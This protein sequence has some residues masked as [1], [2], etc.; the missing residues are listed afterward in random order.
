MDEN[1][2]LKRTQRGV[3]LRC[4]VIA[5]G[6]IGMVS[7]CIGIFYTTLAE[8]MHTGIGAIS[9]LVTVTSIT[10]ALV[11]SQY[12][13]LTA[14]WPVKRLMLTGALLCSLAFFLESLADSLALLYAAGVIMGIGAC[15]FG[16]I[17]LSGII[18]DWYGEK[19]GGPLS[20]TVA[21]SG[22]VGA[23]MNPLLSEI[24]VNRSYQEG[25][26]LLSILLLVLCLPAILTMPMK[27]D[28]SRPRTF[29][30]TEKETDYSD[31]NRTWIIL[32]FCGAACLFGQNALYS[33]ISSIA[34]SS[35]YTL[36]FGAKATSMVMIFNTIFKLAFGQLADRIGVVRSMQ[37]FCCITYVGTF[38]MMCF[39]QI[40]ACMLIAPSFY[41]AGFSNSM[42]GVNLMTQRLAHRHYT[43]VFSKVTMIT[44]L[45]SAIGN[46]VYGFI[47]DAFG[48][49]Q[50]AFLVVTVLNWTGFAIITWL[51]RQMRKQ[52]QA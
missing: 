28:S 10:T 48:S 18:R 40:P 22:I 23:V 50:P 21:M 35:G 4:C 6:S 49:Y 11:S 2:E 12:T 29:R 20:L 31:L 5:L 38:L 36:Q 26:Y 46:S 39:R 44:T 24:I 1:E 9:F 14:R 33:H 32:L 41:A 16:S 43:E 45:T 3:L 25:L 51:G 37:I 52:A 27:E 30:E 13:K 7:N 17:P 19:S 47:R 34:V 15:L 42:I 8:V